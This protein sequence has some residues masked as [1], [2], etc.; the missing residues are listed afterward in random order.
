MPAAVDADQAF[1]RVA[2]LR[3]LGASDRERLRPYVEV[4]RLRR[5]GRVWSQGD[6]TSAFGFV[7]HGRVKLFKTSE[8]GREAIV[9]LCGSGALLCA[10]AVSCFAPYCCSAAAME[11]DALVAVVP[12]R[13]V[14]ELLERSP[15]AGRAFLR[16]VTVRGMSLCERVEEL[17][18]GHVERRI[19]T[20]L[21][22]LA[23]QVGVARAGEGAWIPIALSRQD[24]ADLCG[25]T[26]ETA[27]R[28]MT[29]LRRE[30]VV[31]SAARGLVVTD[32]E[33]LE[34]AARGARGG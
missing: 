5:G 21:L 9:D 11:D 10:S 7:V 3:A 16:E 4:R 1:E 19:A 31:R 29:R 32:R 8:G 26:V 25:T 23:D 18:T 24:L 20:L 22:R 13:D 27:I 2:F 6:E 15:A 34:R 33:S 14:L 30:G 12:R 17:S 28:V